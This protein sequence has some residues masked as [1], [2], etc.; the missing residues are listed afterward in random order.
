M[1]TRGLFQ[2]NAAHSHADEIGTNSRCTRFG[3]RPGTEVERLVEG[4][5]SREPERSVS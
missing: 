4:L 2:R 1:T 3:V 5:P